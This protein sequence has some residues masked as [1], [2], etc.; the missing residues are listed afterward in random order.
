M[1]VWAKCD[2]DANPRHGRFLKKC[3][4]DLDNR[5]LFPT[6]LHVY[7]QNFIVRI[8]YITIFKEYAITI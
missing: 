1:N 8:L 5:M 7:F 3:I 6:S 2:M 4:P